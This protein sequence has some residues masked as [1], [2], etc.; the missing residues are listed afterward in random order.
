MT[1]AAEIMHRG[2]EC[3]GENETVMAAA[4]KMRDLGVGSLP[5][6]GEDDRLHGIITDRD[7]VVKCL[8]EDMDPNECRAGEMAEGTPFCAGADDDVDQILTRMMRHKIK[9]MP[10]ID[11]HRLVGMISESDLAPNLS[12]EQI[13]RLIGSIKSGEADLVTG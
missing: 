10:V 7:I 12:E 4:H 9:R 2:A 5:I 3:V 13:A 8:A 11:N 6:C 1:T